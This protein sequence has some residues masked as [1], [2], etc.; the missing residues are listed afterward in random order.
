MLVLVVCQSD[1]M[2]WRRGA[3]VLTFDKRS[4]ERKFGFIF[5]A[6]IWQRASS[7]P[8]RTW[9]GSA[10]GRCGLEFVL[11]VGHG[12]ADTMWCF[13]LKICAGTGERYMSASLG[14]AC[15]LAGK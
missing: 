9:N 8:R 6:Q 11:L 12:V 13:L 5:A 14:G 4:Q 10:H 15:L 1:S 7:Q 2:D 3:G